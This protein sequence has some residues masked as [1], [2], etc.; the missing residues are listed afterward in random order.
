MVG[1]VR[2][3][4]VGL[5]PERTG[6]AWRRTAL[7]ALG[8]GLLCLRAG[9]G[10]GGGPLLLA[11]LIAIMLS[12]LMVATAVARAGYD[13]AGEAAVTGLAAR[14]RAMAIA[15]AVVAI[16]LLTLPHVLLRLLQALP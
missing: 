9:I 6:L 3:R 13:S 5:Q 7:A 15:T 2:A 12:A 10:T 16:A 1:V 14:R 4:D 11:A 8:V